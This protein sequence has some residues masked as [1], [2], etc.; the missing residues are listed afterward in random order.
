MSAHADAP[1][2]DAASVVLVRRDRSGPRVLMGRRGAAAAFMPSKMVFP[3][4]RVDTADAAAAAAFPPPGPL[5]RAL[6]RACREREPEGAAHD[7]PGLGAALA[8]AAV[9]E[10]WEETGLA[11]AAPLAAPGRVAAPG[12]LPPPWDRFA[13]ERGAPD[14]SRFAMIFRAI[15]PPGRTRRF[16]ARFVMVDAA[17]LAAPD[18]FSGADGELSGLAWLALDDAA[19]EDLPFVTQMVLGEVAVRLAEPQDAARPVPFFHH[20]GGRSY[21]DGLA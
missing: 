6:G 2:H 11:L 5:S 20:D 1:I 14:A 17:G 3:G 18:D 4:G 15:T 21:L 13:A 19:A 16:D 9:R 12:A 7:D 10:L 8:L